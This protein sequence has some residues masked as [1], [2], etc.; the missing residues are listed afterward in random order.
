M[1]KLSQLC[2][3]YV[4]FPKG[5]PMDMETFKN[6]RQS[7]LNPSKWLTIISFKILPLSVLFTTMIA[8]NNL[9]LK[10]VGVAFYYVG[11]SLTTVFNLIFSYILLGEKASLHS[12]MCCGMIVGGFWLGV[13][14]ESVTGSEQ[15]HYS[16]YTSCIQ[17]FFSQIHFHLSEQ[18]SELLVHWACRYFQF[19]LRRPCHML[20]KKCGYLVTTIMSILAFYSFQWC[21]TRVNWKRWH[22]TFIYLNRGSGQHWLSVAF[23]DLQSVSWHHCRLR[24]H[25]HLHIIYLEQPK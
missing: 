25:H 22:I 19:T 17:Q 7:V 12:V 23:A 1:S 16:H 4:S 20:T 14:Q 11:R 2:P 18:F 15:T 5:N 8:T 9:C 24:S 6:V 13:D 21:C 3:G 10:Y